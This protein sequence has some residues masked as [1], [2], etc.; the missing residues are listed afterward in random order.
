MTKDRKLDLGDTP[1]ETTSGVLSGWDYLSRGGAVRCVFSTARKVKMGMGASRRIHESK[2]YWFIEQVDGET[3]EARKINN[4]NVPAGQSETI[5]LHTL[6][7]RFAPELAYY[8]KQV[9]PAMEGLEKILKN[10]DGM[11]EGGRLYSAEMEYGRALEIESGNIRALFGLGLIY[12]G[13]SDSER[14]R[15]LL[16]E[17]VHLKAAFDGKNQHLFNEFGIALRKA[18]LFNESVVYYRRALDFAPEDENLYY[19]L[20][21][22]HYENN[23][24]NGCLESL[25]ISNRLNPDLEVARDLF[26]VIVGLAEDQRLLNT[27]AKP[28][29]PPQ[30]AARAKQILAVETG[31]LPLDDGPVQFVPRGRARSGSPSHGLTDLDII[32]DD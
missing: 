15:S 3:F 8:E 25:I 4:R 5:P 30:I 32:D 14:T 16:T 9:L 2:N 7:K 6:L 17:L 22:A 13:R 28:P 18:G 24:W 10:G 11:R 20:A 27:Y 19:N 21:R 26:K 1:E 23:D 12:A 29:V 31:R